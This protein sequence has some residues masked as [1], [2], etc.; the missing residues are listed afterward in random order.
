[1]FHKISETCK[2]CTEDQIMKEKLFAGKSVFVFG[3]CL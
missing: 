2:L 1:M 3:D